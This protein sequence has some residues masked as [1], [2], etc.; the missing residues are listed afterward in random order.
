MSIH[1]AGLFQAFGVNALAVAMSLCH[2]QVPKEDLRQVVEPG[3]LMTAEAPVSAQPAACQPRRTD[4]VQ[5]LSVTRSPATPGADVAAVLVITGVC[6]G[7][8]GWI[9]TH[10]LSESALSR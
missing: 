1:W 3:G 7:H 5:V 2:A 6:K 9:G 4:R 10:R 8:S